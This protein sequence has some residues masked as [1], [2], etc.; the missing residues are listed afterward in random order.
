MSHFQD[1]G[2]HLGTDAAGALVCLSLIEP[3]RVG[4]PL[5]LRGLGHHPLCITALWPIIASDVRS[6]RGSNLGRF[7]RHLVS[8]TLH[9]SARHPSKENWFLFQCFMG[10]L[11]RSHWNSQKDPCS[12]HETWLG[13]QLLISSLDQVREQGLYHLD[14]LP[15]RSFHNPLPTIKASQKEGHLFSIPVHSEKKPPVHFAFSR[16]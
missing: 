4:W 12:R 16:N 15:T 13:S 1:K 2:L 10:R 11:I 9:Y 3:G 5:E 14:F 6:D 7:N 8:C